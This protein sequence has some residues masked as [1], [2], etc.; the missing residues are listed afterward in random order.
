MWILVLVG[1][2]D[3]EPSALMWKCCGLASALSPYL[4]L[5]EF[6]KMLDDLGEGK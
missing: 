6:Q 1:M 2:N 4:A 5:Q 3:S